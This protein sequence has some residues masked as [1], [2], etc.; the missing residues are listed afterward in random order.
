MLAIGMGVFV[1]LCA[2]QGKVGLRQYPEDIRE[3]LLQ[4]TPLGMPLDEVIK[5]LNKKG[6]SL[7]LDPDRGFWKR[8]TDLVVGVKH[9]E[10]NLGTYTTLF[11]GTVGWQTMYV[12]AYWGFNNKDQLVDIWIWKAGGL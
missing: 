10:A 11:R 12:T 5:V 1:A 9:I 4:E 7:V 3:E 2:W 6:Y 8:D